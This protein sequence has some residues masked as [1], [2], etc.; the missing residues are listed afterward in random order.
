MEILRTTRL[1]LR[2]WTPGDA[3]FIFSLYSD[4]LVM[5]YVTAPWV[6]EARADL[7]VARATENQALRGYCLWAVEDDTGLVGACGL[8]YQESEDAP[9]LGYHF[10]PAAWGRGYATEAAAAVLAY[11]HGTLGLPRIVAATE[12]AHVASQRVLLKI[13][14]R[15]LGERLFDGELAC[16]FESVRGGA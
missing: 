1:R 15:A 13:G 4:P 11:A 8:V 10:R 16:V 5:R 6:S 14:M 3:P 7:A 12:P 2:T 9:E